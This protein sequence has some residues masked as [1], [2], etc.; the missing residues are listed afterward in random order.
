MN[1]V[2]KKFVQAISV[3]LLGAGG[4]IGADYM[5]QES[6]DQLRQNLEAVFSTLPC[7]TARDVIITPAET[8]LVN[9]V[10]RDTITGDSIGTAYE[11]REVKARIVA[12]VDCK[13]NPP[14][15]T[16]LNDT[17]YS[18]VWV[19]SGDSVTALRYGRYL[20]ANGRLFAHYVTTAER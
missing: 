15:I 13:Y 10:V 17:I 20:P 3:F 12:G 5:T 14:Y 8:S 4:Y 18:V 11:M 1:D 6:A 7:D 2:A 9:V 19:K 16:G